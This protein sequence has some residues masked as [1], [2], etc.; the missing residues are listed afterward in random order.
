[1]DLKITG[2]CALVLASS[3]GIGLGIAQSLAA[4][5]VHVMLC[6]RVAAKLEEAGAKIN[7]LGA[8]KADYVV[9]DLS[10]PASA[11]HIFASAREKLGRVDILVN[12]T[13]GPPP[14]SVT[15]PDADL[16]R[17]QF[18]TMILR[19]MEIT[20]LCL[21]GM[22]KAGWGRILTVTS[23]GVA[24]PIPNLG[25][26]NTLRPALIGWSKSLANEVG[27]DGIT[28]NVMLPGRIDTARLGQLDAANSERS[29]RPIGEVRAAAKAAIPLGRYGTVE[30]FGAVAA[31][32]VS[33][34]ASYVTGS[35]V[36]CDGGAI[37]GV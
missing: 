27:A 18:D 14:G 1:M 7:R 12:N 23:S 2:K 34:P 26:S 8:G 33:E 24:Q 4:Q 17:T 29:G 15:D 19:I 37:A 20:H 35:V 28:A 11:A 13:G 30:E 6:G 9:A 5:G 36:R 31:F 25:M 32:L 3:Q 21:P 10:D 16:W 22:R